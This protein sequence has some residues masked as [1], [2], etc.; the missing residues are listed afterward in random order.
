MNWC[1]SEVVL[2]TDFFYVEIGYLTPALITNGQPSW[3]HALI[4]FK[5]SFIQISWRSRWVSESK[6]GVLLQ[7]D[8]WIKLT[9]HPPQRT[10]QEPK[11]L[12]DAPRRQLQKISDGQWQPQATFMAC[13][14]WRGKAALVPLPESTICSKIVQRT[15]RKEPRRGSVVPATTPSLSN[16]EPT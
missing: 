12:Q 13:L 2:I 9:H 1:F 15:K 6:Q 11:T 4:N 7:Q 5:Q 10:R 3:Q 16:W 14:L 8:E